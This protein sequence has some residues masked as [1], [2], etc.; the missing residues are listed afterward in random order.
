MRVLFFFLLAACGAR[1]SQPTVTT[2]PLPTSS[3]SSAPVASD[4]SA[5]APVAIDAS[6][7][8]TS[9][10]SPYAPVAEILR[11]PDKIEA[12]ALATRG[13]ADTPASTPH[14]ITG[15]PITSALRTPPASFAR[16]FAS[17]VLTDAY[18]LEAVQCSLAEKH[19]G[20]RFTRG[21]D[22]VE[23]SILTACPSVTGVSTIAGRTGGQLEGDLS[24]RLAK[25]LRATFGAAFTR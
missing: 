19:I 16:D 17:I 20:L 7:P 2:S 14:R 24:D 11:S 18:R 25:L 6:A 4:A 10:P 5:P 22:V 3:S 23:I 21:A 8:P 1:A 12:F 13:F 9:R 15:Y